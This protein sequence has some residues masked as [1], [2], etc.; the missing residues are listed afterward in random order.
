MLCNWAHE[1]SESATQSME[2]SQPATRHKWLSESSTR[3]VLK[4]QKLSQKPLNLLFEAFYSLIFFTLNKFKNF[5][6]GFAFIKR[7]ELRIAKTPWTEFR[8]QKVQEPSGSTYTISW[9][10]LRNKPL[11]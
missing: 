7:D 3:Y 5:W 6:G 1:L 11:F 9:G 4:M 8:T 2:F 10:K